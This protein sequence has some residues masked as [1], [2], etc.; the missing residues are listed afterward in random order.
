MCHNNN[1]LGLCIFTYQLADMLFQFGFKPLER[2]VEDQSVAAVGKGAGDSH[3]AAHA[4]AELIGV[5]ILAAVKSDQIEQP[6]RR[7]FV[8]DEADVA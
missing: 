6:P 2:L 4:A 8:R 7:R 1:G 5:F 3:S